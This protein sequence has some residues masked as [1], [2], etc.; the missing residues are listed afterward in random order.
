MAENRVRYAVI[1]TE[2]IGKNHI[3]G[4]KENPKTSV[5]TA[6]CDSVEAFAKK[7]A[8]QNGLDKDAKRKWYAFD[9][10]PLVDADTD[11]LIWP[12]ESGMLYTIKL[13]TDY[14]RTA[15][16]LSVA[17]ETMVK[18]C[19][20][21]NIGRKVGCESN[22][23]CCQSDHRRYKGTGQCHRCRRLGGCCCDRG[24]LP[25]WSDCRLL[26]RH[27]LLRRGH[28]HRTDHANGSTGDQ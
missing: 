18:A 25:D 11:T 13:N 5:L 28:R 12:G 1:G 9:S 19:Y 24:N 2:G 3:R 22:C 23:R 21:S 27:I 16:T 14:D 4:I 20:S 6:V 10:A 15:G 7:A 26:F 17:P 8:E